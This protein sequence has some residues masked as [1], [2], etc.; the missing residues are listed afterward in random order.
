MKGIIIS[1]YVL[2]LIVCI[3]FQKKFFLKK[4]NSVSIGI[5]IMSI[6]YLITLLIS[7]IMWN[8]IP[9]APGS[10]IPIHFQIILS[11]I[12]FPLTTIYLLLYWVCIKWGRKF[13]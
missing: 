9:S 12:T 10:K 8:L 13:W 11:V 5:I 1:F 2:A 7:I 4:K 3:I 6:Y